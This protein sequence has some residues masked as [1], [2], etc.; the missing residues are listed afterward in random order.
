M[1][2]WTVAKDARSDLVS[3]GRRS[4]NDDGQDSSTVEKQENFVHVNIVTGIN[5][6]LDKRNEL[7]V[8]KFA[9]IEKI[10]KAH[11]DWIMARVV[12][13]AFQHTSGQPMTPTKQVPIHHLIGTPQNA[14]GNLIDLNHI[15][16]ALP[17]PAPAIS[18]VQ[19]QQTPGFPQGQECPT[20]SGPPHLKVPYQTPGV[21]FGPSASVP[22]V[23][24]QQSWNA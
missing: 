8:G 9:N 21:S 18:Q 10:L 24:P 22:P 19:G 11:D 3:H 23:A 13:D 1:T 6:C 20:P 15:P 17:S 2:R 7:I 4:R 14:D 5:D 12:G 16:T